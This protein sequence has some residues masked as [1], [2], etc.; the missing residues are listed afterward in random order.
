MLLEKSEIDSYRKKFLE[1]GYIQIKSFFKE[2]KDLL[3]LTNSAKECIDKAYRGEWKSIKI[4]NEYPTFFNKI[5]LFGITLPLNKSL[6]K[7]T[8]DNFQKLKYKN[9]I[10]KIL[11]W[12]NF[13]TTLVRLHTKSDFYN[14]QGVWHRDN[15]KFPSPNSIQLI[16]YLKD[17]KGFRIVPKNKNYALSNYEI[18]C[19]TQPDPSQ[20]FTELPKDMY[21]TIEAS[22]GD[23]VIFESGLLHQGFVKKK[24]F[25]FI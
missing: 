15:D 9:D 16:I 20:G 8:Y 2:K 13:Q 25:I 4:Y 19:E 5:N 3:D 22:K 10:L 6:V 1:E 21:V 17:E 24:D 12:K 23:I 14:Y 18:P 11:N 7:D